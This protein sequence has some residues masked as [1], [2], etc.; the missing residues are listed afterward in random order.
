MKN[1]VGRKKEFIE[2]NT[3]A[4]QTVCDISRDEEHVHQV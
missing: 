3:L 1:R 4:I 2:K